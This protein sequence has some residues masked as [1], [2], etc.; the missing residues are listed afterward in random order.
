MQ[1]TLVAEPEEEEQDGTTKLTLMRLTKEEV[2]WKLVAVAG[3]L[4][5]ATAA[6]IRSC[7][8]GEEY[9]VF[10]IFTESGKAEQPWVVS[11]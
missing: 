1:R 7:P 9:S 10:R 3:S 8:M 11:T 6:D 2:Q 5:T 4:A